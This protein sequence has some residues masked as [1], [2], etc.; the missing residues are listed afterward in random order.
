MSL[1]EGDKAP[2]FSL[3]C[4]GGATLSSNDLL[5]K[6]AVLYFYPKDDT[7]GCTVEALDFTARIKEFHRLS[8]VVVGISKDSCAVHEKF[9]KK[10]N[11]KIILASDETTQML[12]KYG[13]WK[14]KSM[15]GR[16]YMGIERSTFLLDKKGKIAKIWHKVKVKDHAEH[17]MSFIKQESLKA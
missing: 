17:V 9:R 6:Y 10:H 7:P 2:F 11:L 14:E 12:E 16:T 8:T 13:V 5:G 4:E 15:Y 3:P 1:C